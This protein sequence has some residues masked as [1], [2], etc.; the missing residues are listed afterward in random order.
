MKYNIQSR[1]YTFFVAIVVMFSL[2][3]LKKNNE[4]IVDE[5][6]IKID[7]NN[8]Y[9]FTYDEELRKW[10]AKNNIAPN[11]NAKESFTLIANLL[12]EQGVIQIDKDTTSEEI[13]QKM[14]AAGSLECTQY[15]KNAEL[16][17]STG[18]NI[19]R[20]QKQYS[21]SIGGGISRYSN[22]FGSS[23]TGKI[24][25][26]RKFCFSYFRISW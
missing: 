24:L 14:I 13:Q 20:Y 23:R 3:F 15:L 17:V 16:S 22:G 18:W 5:F 10:K 11:T 26:S 1:F 21:H 12:V 8:N 9:Y 6:P 19:V 4:K 7:P 25:S 2:I